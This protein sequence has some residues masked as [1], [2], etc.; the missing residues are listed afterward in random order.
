ME[1]TSIQDKKKQVQAVVKTF[2][3]FPKKGVDFVDYFSILYHPKETQLL[4]EIVIEAVD[5]HFADAGESPFNMVIGLETRGFFL[6]MVLSQHYNIPF[7]PIRKKGK[8]PGETECANY[9]TEYEEKN[10]AEIQKDS[11]N[12]DSKALIIDDLLATG[13]TLRMA[14]DLVEKCGAQ[15]AAS[16]V[17]FE[18][19]VLE[20]RKKLKDPSS[21]IAI[22]EY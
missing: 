20:G 4:N 7:V 22:Y 18:I 19:C 6:G 17:V 21:C 2:P 5:K 8:L 13:G 16:L 10:A 15:V 11:I 9:A 3:D 14:Y 1:A 12:E